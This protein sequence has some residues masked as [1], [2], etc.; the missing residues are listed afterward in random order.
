MTDMIRLA[1]IP[2]AVIPPEGQT[3]ETAD[4]WYVALA[5]MHLGQLAF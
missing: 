2:R 5:E 3:Y 1:N 4:D